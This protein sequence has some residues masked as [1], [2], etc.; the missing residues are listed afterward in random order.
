MND[1]LER[2]RDDMTMNYETVKTVVEDEMEWQSWRTG[3]RNEMGMG[4]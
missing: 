2:L 1:G 3:W 4:S